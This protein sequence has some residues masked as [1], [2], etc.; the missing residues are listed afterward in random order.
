MSDSKKD[1]TFSLK[2]MVNEEKRKVL[3]ADVDSTFADV[4]LSFLTLPLGTIVRI[5]KKHYEDEQ[6]VFGSLTTLYNGLENLDSVHFWTK[7]AKSILLHPQSSSDDQRKRLKLDVSDSPP[8]EYFVCEKD[9]DES[10]SFDGESMYH[11][12]VIACKYSKSHSTKRKVA[13]IQTT[14]CDDGVFTI[15][16]ASFVVTDDLCIVPT[17]SGLLQIVSFLGITDMDKAKQ[18]NVTFG[19]AE[20]IALLKASLMSSTPLSDVIF[21]KTGQVKSTALKLQ[22][23][24][25]SDQIGNAPISNSKKMTLKLVVQKSTNKVLY[26]QAEEDFVELLFSFL[27]IPLGGV[28]RLLASNS[29]NKCMDL[30]YMSVADHIHSKYLKT[31]AR[32]LLIKPKIPH[33]YVSENH[34][35]PLPEEGLSGFYQDMLNLFSSVKFPNGRGKYLKAPRTFMVTDDLT[36][37]PLCIASALSF[38]NE[39][40]IP[41]SDVK[42]VE[43]QIGLKEALDILRA[44]LTSDSALSNGLNLSNQ[45]SQKQ[46]NQGCQVQP[47]VGL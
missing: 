34:I 33:G 35:L 45:I 30:L 20:V 10:T 41:M 6:P 27:I 19:Y 22:H 13:G 15:N 44:S 2:A 40:K 32:N 16:T 7:G 14:P 18:V 46:K 42:E 23:M 8:A 11:D 47:Q 24:T 17:S 21:S 28:Q 37:T 39:M 43:L 31:G 5:L 38:L 25:L 1:V 26:A 29:L 12:N 3:F 9:C 4:L 36:V